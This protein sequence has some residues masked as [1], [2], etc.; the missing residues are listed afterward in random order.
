MRKNHSGFAWL[1]AAALLLNL[2][3]PG[4]ALAVDGTPTFEVGTK[5]GQQGDT[6]LEIPIYVKNNPGVSS[7]KLTISFDTD[8]LELTGAKMNTAWGGSTSQSPNMQSPYILNWVNG[9]SEYTVADSV[10]ATLT[11][12]IRSDAQAGNANISITYDP[13]DVCDL[14]YNNIEF[15]VQNGGISVLKAPI[16]AATAEVS[17]PEKGVALATEVTC[18]ANSYSGEAAWYEG[19]AATGEVVSGIAKS[20]QIYTVKITLTAAAGEKFAET[21]NGTTTE[22]GYRIIRNSETELVLTKTFEATEVKALAT[23]EVT[24]NPTKMTYA[25]GDAFNANGMI[26]KATYDDNSVDNDF[27]GYTVEY[28]GGAAQT[29]LKK[30]DNKV[31]LKC[32]DETVEASGLVVN[33]KELTI[34]DLKAV[35]RE[36]KTGDTSVTLIGGALSGVVPGETVSVTMPTTGTIATADAGNAKEVSV[37]APTLDGADSSHYTLKPISG[38]KVNIARKDIDGAT[39]T[40]GSAPTYN[41]AE[42]TISVT[43][44][45]LDGT[46][47]TASTDYTISGNKATNVADTLLTVAGVGNYTGTA[48]T[49]WKLTPK[50]VTADMIGVVDTQTY[51][52]SAI[53]PEPAI[54]DNGSLTKGKD[55]D[56]DYA[57]NI[58][59]GTAAKVKIIG[60]GNYTGSAEKT[61]IIQ[62]ANQLPIITSTYSLA[63]G[64]NELDLTSLVSNAKGDVSFSIASGDAATLSGTTLTSDASKTGDVVITVNV[65]GKDEGGDATN[66]Y[67]P[68]T[69]TNAITVSVTDKIITAL[70]GGVSQTGCTFGEPLAIPSYTKPEGTTTETIMYRGVLRKDGSS[71]NSA[72]KPTEAGDYTVSV[73]CETATHIYTASKTFVIAPKDIADAVVTLS[74]ALTYDGTS[75]TQDVTKVEVNST[76][77]TNDCMVSDNIQTN[78]GT[79][80]LKVAAKATSNYTGTATKTFTIAQKLIIPTVEVTGTYSYT[81]SAIIPTFTVKDGAVSLAFTDYT[82]EV[83]D[84]VDAGSGKITVTT[85]RDGNY[86]FARKVENFAIE[87]VAYSGDSIS[88]TKNVIT[89]HAATGVEVDLTDAIST[90]KGAAITAVA[91]GADENNI[92]SNAA[93]SGSKVTFDVA[94]VAD[95][96]KTT[97][98]NV[99]VASTNYTDITAVITIKTVDKT[100]AGITIPEMPTAK[101]YGDADFTITATVAD[102]GEGTGVW[103]WSSSDPT[104]LAVSGTT[105]TAAVKVL[106]SGSATLKV[107]YSS[108]TTIGEKTTVAITIGKATITITAKDQSIYTGAELPNLSAPEKNTHYTV[109]G[110][111]GEDALGGTIAMKYQKD[112]ADVTPDKN[113]PGEYD[114]VI[115]GATNSDTEK[116]NDIVFA[117]G[118]LTISN[119]PSSGGSSSPSTYSPSVS[120]ADNGSVSLSPR[121]AAKGS[122][123]TITPNP[124]KGYKL[125]NLA[126]TDRKGN[127]IK[128]TEKDGKFTFIMPG[129]GVKVVPTFTK[130]EEQLQPQTPETV[131]NP[132]VDVKET[133]YYYDAT[134]WAAEKGIT[135]GVSETAFG[136]DADCTR[137]QIVTFLWRAAG[138]PAPKAATMS[139]TD[140]ASDAYY[141]DAVLWAVEQGITN[142]IS[143][144]IFSPNTVCT[145][146]QTVTFLYRAAGSPAAG[147]SSGFTDVESG[148]YFTNGVKWAVENSITNGTGAN[149]FNPN[150]SCTRGQIVTFLYRWIGK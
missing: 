74:T 127:T 55:F 107:E 14:G 93:F 50:S 29:Y 117:S 109:T 36:Y 95:K 64:G 120:A 103:T 18:G 41:K 132:F 17:A 66:E 138:S 77:I 85:K 2:V 33:A 137:A 19:G 104:V 121:S 60:K 72:I 13:D 86:T 49:T 114:I 58:Y 21:L 75:Q 143:T 67:N 100:E 140:V 42:Q 122:E 130:I 119:R 150:V 125:E 47:L 27:S 129:A 116:Y 97:T 61:F 34:T 56:Y 38:V 24:R 80:K 118:K 71:Y 101:I 148:A 136:P 39:I 134:L 115:S 37:V 45:E 3:L 131:Q 20:S 9:T 76:D 144:N 99:N 23:M 84:N 88:I 83:T 32:G 43:K 54:T 98:I 81:G 78:A 149:I 63:K 57:D 79:Y 146:A 94:S 89:N 4:V 82:A 105:A 62:T 123:V 31:I 70:P 128:L 90:I 147:A 106:K 91:E 92:I 10:F 96:N 16:S 142:G 35:G 6:E 7:T 110:L 28:A 8:R 1:L 59:V 25:H 15:S 44:V 102:A 112:G 135:K 68:Y 48:T 53:K 113:K 26:V 40:L 22:K 11:F 87:K 5:Q 108:D 124:E 51:T 139:F 145:R 126:V 52:G 46:E 111:V 133:D 65:A 30:D 141:R 69:G 12:S 73:T